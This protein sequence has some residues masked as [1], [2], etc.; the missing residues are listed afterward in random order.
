MK[1]SEGRKSDGAPVN[2]RARGGQRERMSMR[3]RTNEGRN[4]NE[5]ES[6]EK[7]SRERG[8]VSEC[9]REE[10]RYEPAKLRH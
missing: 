2:E 1:L 8:G 3:E 4:V 9:G 10:P 5:R 7:G 6:G